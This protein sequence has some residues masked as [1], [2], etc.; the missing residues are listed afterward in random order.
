MSIL[1]RSM[2]CSRTNPSSCSNRPNLG[3]RRFTESIRW[4]ETGTASGKM[5][6]KFFAVVADDRRSSPPCISIAN[7]VQIDEIDGCVGC[8]D[9]GDAIFEPRADVGQVRITIQGLRLFLLLGQFRSQVQFVVIIIGQRRKKLLKRMDETSD[10]FAVVI[11]G[12]RKGSVLD[13]R[14][15]C[16]KSNKVLSHA[17]G[18]SRCVGR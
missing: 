14:Q 9:V 16:G 5:P 2:P 6:D 1:P 7:P 12:C 3:S 8:V 4:P 10:R 11:Q 13:S 18:K 15:L 17:L